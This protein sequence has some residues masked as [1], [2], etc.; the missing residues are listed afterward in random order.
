MNTKQAF[1]VLA[2]DYNE[3]DGDQAE[4]VLIKAGWCP[5]C[6]EDGERVKLGRF[7]P[8]TSSTYGGLACPTCEMFWP[9]PGGV[10]NMEPN[11]PDYG[12]AFDGNCVT[13]DADPGL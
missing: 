7:E 11:E 13:S 8:P 12:G 6:A 2:G 10:G 1:A 9:T 4:V 3:R 5:G